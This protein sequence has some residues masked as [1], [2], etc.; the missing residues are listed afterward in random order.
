MADF[1][2]MTMLFF[3]NILKAI[4]WYLL[5]FVVNKYKLILASN[6]QLHKWDSL[7]RGE[8]E[9]VKKKKKKKSKE[10]PKDK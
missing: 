4:F 7:F 8:E 3:K 2:V 5:I 6:Q 1:F 10:S 9:K